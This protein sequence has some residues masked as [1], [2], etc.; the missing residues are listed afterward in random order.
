V[1]PDYI[2]AGAGA[3]KGYV[4]AW[5]KVVAKRSRD[6]ATASFRELFS[7]FYQGKANIP[8]NPMWDQQLA[9]INVPACVEH[10]ENGELSS[11]FVKLKVRGAR[12]KIRVLFL[13]D[14]IVFTD[15]DP[16]NLHSW[17]IT[18]HYL[19]CQPVDVWVGLVSDSLKYDL[20]DPE[21]MVKACRMIK[22]ALEADVSPLKLN[23]GVWFFAAYVAAD[24]QRL[25]TL[26]S[27]RSA[28]ALEEELQL[29]RGFLP[30]DFLW[31]FGG[32]A[33]AS[34]DAPASG[35]AGFGEIAYGRSIR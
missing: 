3:A 2:G 16:A 20:D 9:A 19:Y 11:A 26:L 33:P 5:I 4:P 31:A 25:K 35:S 1:L 30:S 21:T 27:A 6:G 15:A 13:R 28:E 7:N 14:L 18:D 24:E 29:M 17:T 32:S 34:Q 8:R 22:L 23:Q 10:V 12:H